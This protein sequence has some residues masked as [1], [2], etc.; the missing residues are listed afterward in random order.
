MTI[1]F[2]TPATKERRTLAT[3]P[4]CL[5]LFE[6]INTRGDESGELLHG[7][8]VVESIGLK[9]GFR[10]D[11]DPDDDE[12]RTRDVLE[13]GALRVLRTHLTAIVTGEA[14]EPKALLTSLFQRYRLAPHFFG[15]EPP[16]TVRWRSAR[17]KKR[18]EDLAAGAFVPTAARFFQADLPCRVKTCES[19]DCGALFPDV[20]QH[21]TRRFCSESCSARDRQQRL[22]LRR[23]PSL[24]RFAKQDYAKR[25]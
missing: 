25:A 7:S 10:F 23:D 3:S 4:E 5:F 17:T 2:L 8:G 22:R 21:G 11:W 15:D 9:Y 1:E 19:W 20:S 13:I 12:E 14:R 6:F 16:Y 24:A 18:F